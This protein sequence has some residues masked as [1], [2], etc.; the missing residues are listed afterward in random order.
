M[1]VNGDSCSPAKLPAIVMFVP[2][3]SCKIKW[4]KVGK[5]LGSYLSSGWEP[6]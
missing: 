5:A 3:I 4:S 2:I 6:Q 1:F